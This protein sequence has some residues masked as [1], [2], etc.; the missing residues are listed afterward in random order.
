MAKK[1]KGNKKGEKPMKSKTKRKVRGKLSAKGLVRVATVLLLM[2][3][4]VVFLAGCQTA[5]P[6][7][8]SN[9]ADYGGMSIV[10]NGN[11]NRVTIDVGDGVTSDA[12]GGGDTQTSTPT[13]ST[14][15]T[16][17]AAAAW[18][19]SSAANEGSPGQSGDFISS[20]GKLIRTFTGSGEAAD[21]R[22]WDESI[23]IPDCPDGNCSE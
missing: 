19:A 4:G 14:D 5:D 9:L 23:P 13:L 17:K 1:D 2:T 22:R 15:V 16:T 21:T 7:S 8:R 18:G 3:V 11:N 6:S 10:V 20:V 12:S